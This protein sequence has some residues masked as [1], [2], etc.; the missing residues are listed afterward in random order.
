MC[1][2][3]CVRLYMCVRLCVH[4]CVRLY[5]CVRLCVCFRMCVCVQR[6]E[7]DIG[8]CCSGAVHIFSIVFGQ[9]I[10]VCADVWKYGRQR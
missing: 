9:C 8:S 2:H 3:V 1:V 10:H 6:Q 4:V 5:V 7:D